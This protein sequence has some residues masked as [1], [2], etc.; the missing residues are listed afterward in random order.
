MNAQEALFSLPTHMTDDVHEDRYNSSAKQLDTDISHPQARSQPYQHHIISQNMI[1]HTLLL[2]SGTAFASAAYSGAGNTF[3]SSNDTAFVDANRNPNITKSVP[4]QMGDRNFTFR[5]AVAEFAP[6]V[7]TSVQ[8][9]RI[10][11][12]FYSL[13]WS[14]GTSLNDT[15]AAAESLSGTQ[16]PRLCAS[17]PLGLLSA[18]TNNGY[19]EKDDGGCTGALGKDCVNDLMQ[20]SYDLNVGCMSNLP[21][22]CSSKLDSGGIGSTCESL[23]PISF[24]CTIDLLSSQHSSLKTRLRTHPVLTCKRLQSTSS[25]GHLQS[26]L[27]EMIL[28]TRGSLSASMSSFSLERILILFVF[29]SRLII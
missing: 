9:S 26:T 17:L 19:N 7:N 29:V 12:S 27:L 6:D 3:G 21:Q 16:M 23:L 22:S 18:S 5:V 13:E 15:V 2:I 10:A 28:H 24:C 14:G 4:F 8:N 25:T 11:A 1:K 20:A